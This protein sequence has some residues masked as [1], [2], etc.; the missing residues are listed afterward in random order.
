VVCRVV[1][2]VSLLVLAGCGATGSG[3]RGPGD[4]AGRL[5]AETKAALT[6][7]DGYHIEGEWADGRSRVR[8]R[9][10]FYDGNASVTFVERSGVSEEI[11][12][13]GVAYVHA[14]R[15]TWARQHDPRVRRMAGLLARSWVR[16]PGPSRFALWEREWQAQAVGRCLWVAGGR[17]VNAGIRSLGGQR[18]VVLRNVGD[19]RVAWAPEIWVSADGAPR[20]LRLRLAPLRAG[21]QHRGSLDPSCSPPS[22]DRRD[23]ASFSA[24]IRFSAYDRVSAISA[25]RRW[26]S[27]AVIEGAGGPA[28]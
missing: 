14:T 2:F 15:A 28:A 22:V 27:G 10:D 6:T 23:T 13:D 19:P 5:L 16:V 1:A 20:L 3:L 7:V 21:R 25:P 24:D 11:V 18:A 9:G 17:L 4:D 12:A 8:M 26:L